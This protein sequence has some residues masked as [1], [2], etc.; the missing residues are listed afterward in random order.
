MADNTPREA[1]NSH[2]GCFLASL[3]G[4]QLF[5]KVECHY[6]QV[7]HTHNE[8]DQRFS[9]MACCIKQAEVLESI[10]DL[11]QYLRDHMT[12]ACGRDLVIEELSNTMDFKSWFGDVN[13]HMQ[14]LTST[15][16]EPH[17]NHLWRFL[18]RYGLP[19]DSE[20]IECH[21]SGWKQLQEHPHDVILVV[22]QFLSSPNA[23][24]KPQLCLPASLL[25]SLAPEK[26]QPSV[27]NALSE[28]VLQ[29]FR[30]TAEAVSKAPWNLLKAQIFLETL[31]EDNEKNVVYPAM[32]LEFIL[33]K[34]GDASQLSFVVSE[35][36]AA[37]S[38]N[39]ESGPGALEAAGVPV[40]PPR[41]VRVVPKSRAKAKASMRRPSCR[42][43]PA[44]CLPPPGSIAEHESEPA[45]PVAP[46]PAALEVA[47]APAPAA[48]L[49]RC[50]RKRPAA[51]VQIV[52]PAQSESARPEQQAGP[53]DDAEPEALP[54]NFHYGCSKCR[55]AQ[56][57]CKECQGF[58]GLLGWHF[59]FHS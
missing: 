34:H 26:L 39:G 25:E 27:S 56:F 51:D 3:V 49:V 41:L 6:L 30:R 14:G 8:L 45:A 7:D 59:L 5:S 46:G 35:A 40:G 16:L 42:L 21:H 32:K 38:E 15:H 9:S 1:K 29:E 13:L 55:K 4:A 54:A 44:A 2:F 37:A 28:T 19:T 24:Q 36:V 50:S 17:V 47:V 58:L 10:D 22:K 20:E 52:P 11:V 18:P 31:C 33:S 12:A 48:P 23:S 57:G 53:E 43:R